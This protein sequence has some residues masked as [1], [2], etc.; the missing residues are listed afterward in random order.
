[1]G[2]VIPDN[3]QS[4]PEPPKWAVRFFEWYCNPELLEEIQG[5]MYEQFYE[6]LESGNPRRARWWYSL[7]VILFI[8]RYTLS[9]QRHFF[10]RIISPDMFRNYLKIGFR[11]I[12]K[13]KL[14]SFINAFGLALAV[15]CCLVVYTFVNWFTHRDVFHENRQSIYVVERMVNEDGHRTL[16]G[17]TPEPLGP[18]LKNDLSMVHDQSRFTHSGGIFKYKD[19][20]F[21]E[22]L[23]FV[24]NSFYDIF[25]FPVKWGNPKQFVNSDA[26]VLSER[27]SERYF[28]NENPIGQE[29]SIRFNVNG[30]EK[31]EKFT[32]QGVM[33]AFPESTSIE[34]NMLIPYE[35]QKGLFVQDF[36]DWERHAN[37]TFLLIS[38]PEAIQSLQ[39]QMEG[40]LQQYNSRQ[41]GWPTESLHFEPLTN[42]LHHAIDVNHSTFNTAHIAG[43][44]MLLIIVGALL[45][46][47][48]FNYMNIAVASANTRLKEIGIRKVMGGKRRQIIVQFLSENLVLCT[49]SV[50]IGLILAQY[51][52]LPW[53]NGISDFS[54]ELS[55]NIAN[56]PSLWLFIAGL[57][58]LTA[59]GG[60]GYPSFYISS[61]KPVTVL[62]NKLKFGG[63]NQFRKIL[64]GLQFILS[65][66]AIFCAIAFLAVGNEAR[67]KPWG[68]D[69]EGIINVRL[70]NN[71]NFTALK[72]ELIKNPNI[73]SVA[74]AIHNLSVRS[75][76]LKAIADGK[77]HQVGGLTIG[78][79]YVETM[80]LE[81]LRGRSFSE[82]NPTDY[83]QAILVNEKFCQRLG[84]E[85]PLGK[86]I[87]IDSQAFLVIGEVKNFYQEAF[88]NEL[89]PFVMRLAPDSTL[90]TMV[91]RTPTDQMTQTAKDIA[92]TW[93]GFYP[94]IPFDHYFQDTVFDN[95]FMAF[96]QIG[97]VLTATAF[98]TIIISA[99]GLFGLALLLLSKKMKELSIRKVLGANLLE[100][101]YQINKDFLFTIIGAVLIGMPLG[102]FMLKAILNLLYPE[103]NMGILPFILA[104]GCLLVMTLLSVAR[105]IYM[106]AVSNPARHLRDE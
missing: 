88:D 98:L 56:N 8:N 81:I 89:R 83:E 36:S 4:G 106:V 92:A 99:I 72:N 7:N 17:N 57:I 9:G 48:C 69:Q 21:N 70:N 16:W 15:G 14:S 43:L 93:K 26:I 94:D 28:G 68:Y 33:D 59:L 45:S 32:V 95:Y 51:F 20:V 38:N 103:A 19:R 27:A 2:N 76:Q 29:V 82:N 1:M 90:S 18:A 78:K 58:V 105:H 3:H 80:G 62:Q 37:A 84:W 42:M 66:L 10:T 87:E 11:N 79:Q 25:D 73:T 77:I 34:F 91:I 53:F 97:D 35:R 54:F 63:K 75:T 30:Q 6:K 47:A 5:D 64:L 31:T 67:Q 61:F 55:L 41:E 49:L 102:Y 74:G 50:F 39:G 23:T 96:T 71:E 100:L 46:L 12:V 44:I 13:N 85:N 22:W 101:S 40:Y 52:F 24:D 86:K 65:F 60:A 104:I